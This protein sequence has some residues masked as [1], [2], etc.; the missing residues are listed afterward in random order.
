MLMAS[1]IRFSGTAW[2][3]PDRRLLA[4]PL[5]SVAAVFGAVLLV[6][7]ILHFFSVRAPLRISSVAAGAPVPPG[8]YPIIEDIC[9]VSGNGT[10]DF[11]V[12]LDRRYRASPTFRT[13]L[14]QMSVFWALGALASAGGTAY[15]VLDF[16]DVDVAFALGWT[17]PFVWAGVWFLITIL[18]VQRLLKKEQRLWATDMVELH[19]H[20]VT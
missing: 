14:R 19:T 9:A 11:R 6:T 20:T 18:W 2:K 3:E 5:S 7:D 17:V 4:L 13:M 12:A 16:D 1:L 8:I 15:L 10:T